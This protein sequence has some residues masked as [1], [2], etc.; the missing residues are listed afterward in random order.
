MEAVLDNVE[1]L[2]K[3]KPRK[4]HRTTIEHAG[5]FTEDRWG[6]GRGAPSGLGKHVVEQYTLADDGMTMAVEF[7]FEDPEYLTEP[8]SGS[9]SMAFRPG[10]EMEEWDCSTTSARRHLSL[11]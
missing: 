4:D 6:L 7:T 11:D 10:Y 8:V 5:F 3:E 1:K 9:G 2:M